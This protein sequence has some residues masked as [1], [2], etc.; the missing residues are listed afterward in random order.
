MYNTWDYKLIE[1]HL[2]K[3]IVYSSAW[4]LLPIEGRMSFINFIQKK[5]RTMKLASEAGKLNLTVT[6]IRRQKSDY[7][8]FIKLSY[9]T[10]TAE[11]E[12][13]IKVIV[14]HSL[15]KSIELLPI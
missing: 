11:R 9:R 14:N 4:V 10:S 13:L 3:D 5:L 6:K 7:C 2:A 12:V 1:R 8:D 15:I